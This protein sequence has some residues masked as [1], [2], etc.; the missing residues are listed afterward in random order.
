[1]V[2][3]LMGV[4]GVGKTA[5]G[6]RLAAGL[7]ELERELRPTAARLL[8]RAADVPSLESLGFGFVAAAAGVRVRDLD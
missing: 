3:I 1:V 5:V 2:V 6:Q 8:T 7:W 4:S